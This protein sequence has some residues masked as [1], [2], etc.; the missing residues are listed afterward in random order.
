MHDLEN[1]VAVFV[2]KQA[3]CQY[4]HLSQLGLQL[5]SGHASTQM[6]YE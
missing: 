3:R 4:A 6:L 5:L 2:I 1:F